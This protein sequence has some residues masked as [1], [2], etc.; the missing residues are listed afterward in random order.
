MRHTIEYS[1]SCAEVW[2]FYW[3]SWAK[4]A[5]LW[6]VH[7]AIASGIAVA[8]ELLVHGSDWRVWRVAG[9]AAVAGLACVIL[10]PLWPLWRF[11]GATRV[12]SIDKGGFT[13]TIGTRS[14]ERSWQEIA[15]VEDTGEEILIIVKTGNAM[16]VPRRAFANEAARARFLDD[17]RNWHSLTIRERA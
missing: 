15:A 13:T 4:P 7:L 10:F 8:S 9:I 12:L 11:K 5:G 6:R 2:R 17:A 16:V 14:G 3:R 1:S